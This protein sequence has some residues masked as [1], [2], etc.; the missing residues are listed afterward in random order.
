MLIKDNFP[1]DR[2]NDLIRIKR[3]ISVIGNDDEFLRKYLKILSKSMDSTAD[4]GVMEFKYEDQ[5]DVQ[6]KSLMMETMFKYLELNGM[7]KEL[8]EL[9][10]RIAGSGMMNNNFARLITAYTKKSGNADEMKPVLLSILKSEAGEEIKAEIR[11]I[12]RE[13]E[14]S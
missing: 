12:I 13:R 11:E 8:F 9:S 10:L 14:P 4:T 5:T 1:S 3:D 2:D 7:H 6:K